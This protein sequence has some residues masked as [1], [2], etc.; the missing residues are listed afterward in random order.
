MTTINPTS[1][2]QTPSN[3]AP[4]RSCQQLG[5]CQH[6]ETTCSAWPPAW[7]TA[8]ITPGAHAASAAGVP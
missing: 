1:P 8:P 2:M 6:P 5:V 3:H 7:W 4:R